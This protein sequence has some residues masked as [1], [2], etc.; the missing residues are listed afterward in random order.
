MLTTYQA[1]AKTGCRYR[2][3]KHATHYWV[4]NPKRG[5]TMRAWVRTCP[6]PDGSER[7]LRVDLSEALEACA[8]WYDHDDRNPRFSKACRELSALRRAA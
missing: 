3:T 6:A 4:S 2:Y 5:G 7:W 8:G 1:P